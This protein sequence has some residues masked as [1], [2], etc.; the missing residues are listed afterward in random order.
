M[1]KKRKR[2]NR[3]N[4]TMN[5]RGQSDD[6]IAQQCILGRDAAR[7]MPHGVWDDVWRALHSVLLRSISG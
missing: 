6:F 5:N 3:T 7:L 4:G 2:E 1:W